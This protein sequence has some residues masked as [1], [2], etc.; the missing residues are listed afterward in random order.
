MDIFPQYI[1]FKVDKV[2]GSKL[3]KISMMEGIRDDGYFEISLFQVRDSEAYTI[4]SN[5]AFG[6]YKLTG[7]G[8]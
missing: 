1:K 5:R 4:D 6:H 7:C 3:V 2:S 8:W